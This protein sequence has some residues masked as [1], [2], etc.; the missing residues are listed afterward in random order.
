MLS[1]RNPLTPAVGALAV[2][3]TTL[4]EEDDVLEPLVTKTE[5]PVAEPAPPAA[6]KS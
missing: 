2:R 3:I 4:P 5:P 1:I 6:R